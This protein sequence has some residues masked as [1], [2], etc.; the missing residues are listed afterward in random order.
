[1]PDREAHFEP[2]LHL[3]DVGDDEA[4]IAWGGFW[5][6]R[7]RTPDGRWSIVDDEELSEVAGVSRTET[8]GA[9]SEP[10]GHAVV[11]VEREGTVVAR[12]ETDERNH[13]WVRGLEPDTEYGYRVSVDGEPWADGERWDWDVERQTLVRSG[14]RYDNRF[15]TFPAPGARVPVR[16]AVLGDF[17][18]G[19]LEEDEDAARQLRLARALERGVSEHGARLVLTTG[20]NIYLGEEGNVSGTGNEDDDWY[21]SFYQPYRYLLNRVPFFPTV[22]NHDAGDTERSDD[23]EQ[24]ADNYFIEERFRPQVEPGRASLDPGLFYRFGVGDTVEFVCI[25]TS[26]AG[27]LEVDHYFDDPAHLEWVREALR[28][29][30]SEAPRWRIPFSHHPPYCAGPSH[31]STPGMVERLVPLFREAGVAL[32]LSGHEHN[33][34]H[35]VVDGINYVISGAGG[36]LRPEPP[37]DFRGAGTR[38]WATAGHFLLVDADEERLLIHPVAEVREDG[39]LEPIELRDAAGAPVEVPLIVR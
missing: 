25:D 37:T 35:S 18:I 24:L 31:G 21:S 34:Q 8:I 22:G 14:R 28:S 6:S 20:D 17:G 23:R 13:T 32:V 19:I 26:L 10:Y 27:E 9:R 3:A 7:G 11:E 29:R 16:F 4:L 1:M 38:A 12:A 36:K 33:F 5:F 2:F 15:R 30:E 39:T